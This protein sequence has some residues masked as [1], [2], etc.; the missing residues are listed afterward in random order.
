MRLF[1][2]GEHGYPYNFF[3]WRFHIEIEKFFPR[4]CHDVCEFLNLGE[5]SY[6]SPRLQ[7]SW[8]H[9]RVF[10][11]LARISK[12]LPTSVRD[13]A[14][15]LRSCRVLERTIMLQRLARSQWDCR[16]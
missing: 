15:S 6:I 8:H 13:L 7:R 10:L 11:N 1:Y 9:V 16:E 3:L 4:S 5:I 2:Y 12:R 14:I